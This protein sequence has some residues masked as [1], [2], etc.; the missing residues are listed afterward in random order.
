[1]AKKIN[2]QMRNEK[3]RNSLNLLKRIMNLEGYENSLYFMGYY[4]SVPFGKWKKEATDLFVS[5]FSQKFDESV[6][7]CSVTRSVV[8]E[9]FLSSEERKSLAEMVSRGWIEPDK[10]DEDI[11]EE[12]R[13]HPLDNDDT[14]A[15]RSVCELV[16]GGHTHGHLFFVWEKDQLVVYPHE[17]VG[18]GVLAPPGTAGESAG[19]DFLSK[20][21]RT[22]FFEVSLTRPLPDS[23]FYTDDTEMQRRVA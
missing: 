19:F 9:D 11:H 20:A 4:E 21:G 14:R 1:L 17:D 22:G 8:T 3:P 16:V 7:I 6:L 13:I 18:F 10:H 5:F 12:F 23:L 2:R 15:V